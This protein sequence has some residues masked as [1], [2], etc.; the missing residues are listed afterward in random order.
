MAMCPDGSGSGSFRASA[1]THLSTAT[2]LTFRS[3]AIEPKL[4]FAMAYSSNANAFI[5][6][7]RLWDE[8][9]AAKPA[10]AKPRASS[11]RVNGP[12]LDNKARTGA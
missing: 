11:K 10:V 4:T 6:G 9:Y 5:G 2:S 1:R 3:R 12:D 7:F 8:S